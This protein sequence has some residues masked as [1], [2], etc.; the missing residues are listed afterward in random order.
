MA[1]CNI[2]VGC[3]AGLVVAAAGAA[4]AETNFSKYPGFAEF[5]A[6]NPPTGVP[7]EGDRALLRRHAPRFHL[8]AGHEGPIDFYRDYIAH[9]Y[10]VTGDGVRIDGPTAEELNRHRDDPAAVFVHVPAGDASPSVPVVYA[11][12]ERTDLWALPSRAPSEK[13]LL[14]PSTTWCFGRAVCPPRCRGGRKRPWG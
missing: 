6:A 10:L 3:L 11:G 7:N 5:F 12:I 8:P 14:S 9:G 1:R 13:S 2:A 4:A